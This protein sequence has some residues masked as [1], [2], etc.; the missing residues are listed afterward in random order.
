MQKD[1]HGRDWPVGRAFIHDYEVMLELRRQ[2]ETP[3][4]F[5]QQRPFT[6]GNR[7]RVQPLRCEQGTHV[8]YVAVTKRPRLSRNLRA[9][10]EDCHIELLDLASLDNSA[11]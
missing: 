7:C 6:R 11:E 2:Q 3:S 9:A 8:V 1:E 10:S 5:R 4:E